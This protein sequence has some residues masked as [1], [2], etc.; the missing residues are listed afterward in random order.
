MVCSSAIQVT[1]AVVLAFKKPNLMTSV[2]VSGVAVLLGF[3]CTSSTF[4]E[5]FSLQVSSAFLGSYISETCV[6]CGAET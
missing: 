5:T 2:G 6:E 1:N 4:V 3:Y